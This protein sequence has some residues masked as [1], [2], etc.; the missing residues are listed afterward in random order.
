MKIE[1]P[2]PDLS[3]YRRRGRELD[4]LLRRPS[5]S[6]TRPCPD[7][8]IPCPCAA[9]PTCTCGCSSACEQVPLRMSSDPENH[10]IELGIAP[11]VYCLNELGVCRPCWSCEGHLDAQGNFGRIPSVWFHSESSVYPA[12]ISD[13]L[14]DLPRERKIAHPWRVA[15]VSSGGPLICT[16]AIEPYLT[17]V[18]EPDLAALR[19]P[20]S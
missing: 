1:Q 8:D 16:Y 12:L 20:T 5:A 15:M 2:R 14:Y 3:L 6:V 9:S 11:L 17:H 19:G 10:P 18:E 7:C 13:Y 4:F